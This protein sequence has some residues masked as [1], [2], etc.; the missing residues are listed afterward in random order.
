[1]KVRSRNKKVLDK[2]DVYDL[3]VT[4]PFAFLSN[5]RSS[6]E[7]VDSFDPELMNKSAHSLIDASFIE[8]EIDIARTI[9]EVVDSKILVPRDTKI[10]DSGTPAQR[11]CTSGALTT[12]S[13]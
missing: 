13:P 8:Q 2:T 7:L 3:A 9:R 6:S 4:D 12:G 10:D 11:T 1:M 5:L